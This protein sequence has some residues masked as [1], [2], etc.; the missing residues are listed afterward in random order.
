MPFQFKREIGPADST[1]AQGVR[2]YFPL[3]RDEVKTNIY[4]FPQ[5]SCAAFL[6]SRFL[7]VYKPDRLG[8]AATFE[9][10]FPIEILNA[11]T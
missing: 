7:L 4:T 2:T 1:N 8:G 10:F 3:T 11:A 6:L 9:F 5:Q